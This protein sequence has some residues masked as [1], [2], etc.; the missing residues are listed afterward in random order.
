MSG[1]SRDGKFKSGPA[2]S[3]G[4]ADCALSTAIA[5]ECA[6]AESGI[7][8]VDDLA[9]E[10]DDHRQT[11]L[12]ELMTQTGAQVFI[13]AVDAQRVRPIL[14]SSRKVQTFH[15]KRGSVVEVEA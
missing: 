9:A 7:R 2:E 11:R 6:S 5:V 15:V 13:T 12:W 3:V 1:R 10:L 4:R 8:L 14:D